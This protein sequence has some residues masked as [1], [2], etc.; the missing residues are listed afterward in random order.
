MVPGEAH[1]EGGGDVTK[2]FNPAK[3]TQ[4]EVDATCLKCHSSA[5]PDFQRS[6]HAKANVAASAATTSTTARRRSC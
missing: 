1:V 4:K 6:P 3:A 5:H 2:I